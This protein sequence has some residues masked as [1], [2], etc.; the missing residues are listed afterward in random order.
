MRVQKIQICKSIHLE[1][2]YWKK[3]EECEEEASDMW[4]SIWMKSWNRFQASRERCLQA[5]NCFFSSPW[6]F[7]VA[8]KAA[9]LRHK[10]HNLW[11][12]S[13]QAPTFFPKRE[14]SKRFFIKVVHV[15]ADMLNDL[16]FAA[17]LFPDSWRT[18]EVN[19]RG[20]VFVARKFPTFFWS[21]PIKL[22]RCLFLA[23]P[24]RQQ[25]A[26]SRKFVYWMMMNGFAL[27]QQL[28]PKTH[29]HYSDTRDFC[30][31]QF[32]L[33]VGALRKWTNKWPW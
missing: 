24:S 15:W 21:S 22:S 16:H 2:K 3:M 23:H 25:I 33:E 19:Y 26:Y 7:R 1:D 29:D 32:H 30:N 31:D 17:S 6:L 27:A 8:G 14:H 4:R 20:I 13:D 5:A 28:S 11:L 9:H 12:S 18:N 10:E